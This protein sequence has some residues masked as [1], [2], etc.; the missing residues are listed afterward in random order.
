MKRETKKLVLNNNRR[1]AIIAVCRAVRSFV[2]RGGILSF[3]LESFIRRRRRRRRRRRPPRLPPR[4]DACLQLARGASRRRCSML[5]LSA[6]EAREDRNRP[7]G[8]FARVG[9][10]EKYI[11]YRTVVESETERRVVGERE[12][13]TGEAFFARRELCACERAFRAVY[14]GQGRWE[15][16]I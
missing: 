14:R 12:R 5:L 10:A 4:R 16:R 13:D 9:G 11:S 15:Q 8:I 2:R 1:W 3:S 6:A 7:A